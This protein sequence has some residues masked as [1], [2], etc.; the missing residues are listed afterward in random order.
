M[1]NIQ[2]PTTF[3]AEYHAF[4]FT[5]YKVTFKGENGETL[6]SHYCEEGK[7]AVYPFAQPFSYD[8]ENV[9]LFAGWSESL[10]NLSKQTTVTAST[11]TISRAQ[12]GEYPQTKVVDGDLIAELDKITESDFQDNFSYNGETY[13]KEWGDYFKVEPIQWRWLEVKENGDILYVSEKIL[14]CETFGKSRNYK[15]SSIR[16]WLNGD[17]LDKAFSDESLLV[18]TEVDNSV[19]SPGLEENKNVCENTN[20]K[21]FL[22][23]RREMLNESLFPYN[24]SR[25][26][27][28]TDFV[29][30]D[31]IADYWTRSPDSSYANDAY[32]VD[33]VGNVI[34]G[35][36]G[37]VLRGVR[38]ALCFNLS[39]K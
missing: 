5:G 2:S 27:Y 26:C 29:K 15:K 12:N 28:A 24:E 31:D 9:H 25:I 14:N 20:D 1:S 36:V 13:L 11:K 32:F 19:A 33:F 21:I 22:L 38:P 34:S 39:E 6:H 16:Q 10:D 37:A 30:M 8:S 7:T 23:S 4:T 18:T 17:F 35:G 3:I